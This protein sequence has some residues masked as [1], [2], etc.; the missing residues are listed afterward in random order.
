MAS[1]ECFDFVAGVRHRDRVADATQPGH[2]VAPVADAEDVCGVDLPREQMLQRGPLVGVRCDEFPERVHRPGRVRESGAHL[3]RGGVEGLRCPVQHHLEGR[4]RADAVGVADA[5]RFGRL[6]ERD[7]LVGR[8]AVGIHPDGV[9]FPP[10]QGQSRGAVKPDRGGD[11]CGRHRR[12]ARV[13]VGHGVEG[14]R[15]VGCGYAVAQPQLT[16]QAQDAA[17]RSAGE[18]ED[19][20]PRG[21]HG[22]DRGHRARAHRVVGAGDGSVDVEGDGVDVLRGPGLVAHRVSSPPGRARP[23]PGRGWSRARSPRPAGR[24]G[25]RRVRATAG[26]RPRRSRRRA[27]RP[28]CR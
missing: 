14:D 20:E 23:R 21:V 2:V 9:A 7:Q 13:D 11:V 24:C 16:R 10:R 12:D 28:R 4:V 3:V 5:D 22:G 8:G 6:S 19:R 1:G 18:K 15:T 17:A 25:C 26:R 27:H